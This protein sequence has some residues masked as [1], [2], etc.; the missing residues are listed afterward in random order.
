MVEE[1][2]DIKF[3]KVDDDQN[4]D[5]AESCS[6]IA[7]LT[8]QLFHNGEMDKELEVVGAGEEKIK[9]SLQAVDRKIEGNHLLI[10][11]RWKLSFM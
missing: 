4:S 10:F 8:F 11:V 1:F 5:P 7:I 6:V 3:F 2:P 9:A